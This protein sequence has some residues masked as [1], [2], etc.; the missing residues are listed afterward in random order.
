[1]L[2]SS[3]DYNKVVFTTDY[4]KLN[5]IP[6]LDNNNH[7]KITVIGFISK[8]LKNYKVSNETHDKT[9]NILN[10]KDK[11][12]VKIVSI[13]EYYTHIVLTL[14]IFQILL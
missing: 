9:K 10:T 6:L 8:I 7:C 11:V 3:N 13:M 1:M 5:I 12:L 4:I 2:V 14:N